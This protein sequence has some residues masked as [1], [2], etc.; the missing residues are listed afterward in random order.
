MMWQVPALALTAQAFLL[1]LGLARDTS[2]LG[3][4]LAALAGIVVLSAALQLMMKHRFHEELFSH[5]LEQFEHERGIPHFHNLRLAEAFA[6]DG[7]HPWRTATGSLAEWRRELVV[8]QPSFKVWK[9][10]LWLLLA[11]D[12]AVGFLG[13]LELCHAWM[14]LST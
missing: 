1:Q 7:D 8:D 4:L 10:A 13:I 11:L 12:A 3:R 5:W 6:F 2:G 14:P 9:G